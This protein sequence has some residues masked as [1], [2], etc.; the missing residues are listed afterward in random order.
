VAIKDEDILYAAE[1]PQELVGWLGRQGQSADSVFR[2]PE[3]E[4]A[5][6]GLAPL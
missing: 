4:L 6:A 2:V 1:T 5:A 3:E